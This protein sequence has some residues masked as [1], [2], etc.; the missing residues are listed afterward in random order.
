MY[1][2]YKNE[3]GSPSLRSSGAP[4]S[5]TT[6]AKS[7]L[8]YYVTSY[9]SSIFKDISINANGVLTYKVKAVPSHDNTII[10]VV[11]VVK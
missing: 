9:D 1:T 11:F 3:F 2:L 4:S 5:I 6:Y 10:N 7:E 8:Y